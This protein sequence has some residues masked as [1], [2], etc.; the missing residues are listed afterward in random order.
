M[1]RRK[2][3]DLGSTASRSDFRLDAP[4]DARRGPGRRA[5]PRR[6]LRCHRTISAKSMAPSVMWREMCWP[7]GRFLASVK[8]NTSDR[9]VARL[10]GRRPDGQ[11]CT[12]REWVVSP[13]V[14]GR[15]VSD[16]AACLAR[17]SSVRMAEQAG[18]LVGRR[19]GRLLAVLVA[20]GPDV[21]L[22]V[23]LPFPAPG[24]AWQGGVPPA[25][26]ARSW[27]SA[28]PASRQAATPRRPALAP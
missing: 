23:V 12:M 3:A 7:L 24:P 27:S 10:P 8:P 1:V 15:G 13:W 16:Q 21:A 18:V 4:V 17:P 22:Y 6:R 25:S 20:G 28:R 14:I 5:A 19:T 11:R 9:L 26:S 2:L